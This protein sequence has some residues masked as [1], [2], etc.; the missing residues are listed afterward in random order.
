MKKILFA[1]ALMFA[2]TFG[3]TA[4][5][6]IEVNPDSAGYVELYPSIADITADTTISYDT[7]GD[8][9]DTI[10]T[11]TYDTTYI[12]GYND[13]RAVANEGYTFD[14]WEVI[15]TYNIWYDFDNTDSTGMPAMID[16]IYSDTIIQYNIEYDEDSVLIDFEGWLDWDQGMPDLSDTTIEGIESILVT[17]YFAPDTN[18]VGI[19]DI[20]GSVDFT[21]YPNPT[22]GT[23]A[24]LGDIHWI[25]VMDLNGRVIASTDRP[26]IDLTNQPVG[27]Y[28]VRVTNTAGNMGVAKVIKR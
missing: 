11:I 6:S 17:A 22:S 23:I 21:I 19:R 15:T 27:I 13:L 14:R 20:T 4:Q 2:L 12:P 10:E 16:S 26:V 1:F 28:L 25:T 3:A 9:I 5:T 18:D 7:V 8:V 24:V